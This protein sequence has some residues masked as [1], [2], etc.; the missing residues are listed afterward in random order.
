MASF[1]VEMYWHKGN[2]TVDKK[3][4][5]EISGRVLAAF[6][7]QCL[8]KALKHKDVIRRGGVDVENLRI[9]EKD[10]SELQALKDRLDPFVELLLNS[11]KTY[12]NPIIVAALSIVT[13]IVGLGLPSFSEHLKKFL[14]RIFKLFQQSQATDSDFTNS[15]FKCLSEL[16]KNYAVNQDLSDYQ[17]KTLIEMIKDSVDKLK[18]QGNA[19]Q[20]L[21]S[22]VH[23][24]Y[25]CP[26]L[27]DLIETI[28]DMMISSVDKLTR[29]LCQNI[30]I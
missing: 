19:L 1:K 29:Q 16:I 25:L 12:H 18:V 6:G 28:Q 11:F 8:K 22:V 14:N 23:R 26:E 13:Q 27:Y 9:E 17:I 2:Q 4:T 21:R 3:T 30:F 20:C 5:E 15:L 10:S 7:L 24:R